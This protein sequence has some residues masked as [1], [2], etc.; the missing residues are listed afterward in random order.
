MCTAEYLPHCVD[1]P[2]VAERDVDV[3]HRRV[4]EFVEASSLP[5]RRVTQHRSNV[6][7]VGHETFD[8][9][10]A[11]ESA[12]PGHHDR[13]VSEAHETVRTSITAL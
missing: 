2:N 1:V 10:A 13:L 8:E 4:G 11:D 7:A 12:C 3:G 5:P 6:G 9:S